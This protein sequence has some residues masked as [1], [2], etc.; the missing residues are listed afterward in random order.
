LLPMVD[1]IDGRI[2]NLHISSISATPTLPSSPPN[3]RRLLTATGEL[4]SAAEKAAA[5]S[6][7]LL[8]VPSISACL[9]DVF[10]FL[11]ATGWSPSFRA[12]LY[13]EAMPLGRKI[14]GR[15]NLVGRKVVLCRSKELVV[16]VKSWVSVSRLGGSDWSL[17]V[18][19]FLTYEGSSS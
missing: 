19:S 6:R 14:D 17:C 12:V 15:R 2:L 18:F 10:R 5:S 1:P 9:R 4:E 11:K 13:M 8:I 3:V 7:R 16:I